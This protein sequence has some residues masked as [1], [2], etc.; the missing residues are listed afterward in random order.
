MEVVVAV[1]EPTSLEPLGEMAV[2][3]Q[4]TLV[5]VEAAADQVTPRQRVSVELVDLVNYLFSGDHNG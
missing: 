1:E 3:Q 5:L 2:M 4:Q